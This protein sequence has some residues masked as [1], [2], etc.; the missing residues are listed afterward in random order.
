MSS[1]PQLESIARTIIDGNKYVT[2]ATADANGQPWASPVYY[3]PDGYG[4]LYWASSPD[5]VHSRN[6]AERAEVGMVVF[7]SQV[8]IGGAE[9]VYMAAHVAL[10]AGHDLERCA[11]LYGSRFA[12]LRVFAP[13]ELRPPAP[14][15][16]Y[17]AT[18]TEHSVLVRGSDPVFGRGVD[19]RVVVTL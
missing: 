4:E 14:L 7:D 5:S 15:R 8:P 9:A 10:V 2:L 11:A 16:L 3:T 17:R 12:E 18:V 6:V 19:T 1:H 13:D